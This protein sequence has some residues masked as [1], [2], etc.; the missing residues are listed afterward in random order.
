MIWEQI[1]K[2][3]ESEGFTVHSPKQKMGECV[4]PYLVVKDTGASSAMSVSS[5]WKTFDILCYVPA[6]KYRTLNG[7]VESVKK[8]MDK[9]FP[10]LQPTH[11]ETPSF[12]DTDVKAH[13]ISVQYQN[14]RRKTRR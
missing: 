10:L 9:L 11:F 7:Y 8:A 4:E 12:E 6:S 5:T 13:M 3:L 14:I 1:Y 2:H